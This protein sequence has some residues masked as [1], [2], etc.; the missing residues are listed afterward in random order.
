ME[1]LEEGY[2][3]TFPQYEDIQIKSLVS[4]IFKNADFDKSGRIDYTEYLISAMNKQ[5][6]LSQDKLHKAF[7]SFDLVVGG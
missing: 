4:G 2:R 7:Q 6:L 5:I 3:K 1:E